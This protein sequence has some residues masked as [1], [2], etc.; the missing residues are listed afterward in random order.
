MT[1]TPVVH[2]RM[3]REPD[4]RVTQPR[5]LSLGAGVLWMIGI[6]GAWNIIYVLFHNLMARLLY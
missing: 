3:R 4:A 6:A 2:E 1:S 5:G